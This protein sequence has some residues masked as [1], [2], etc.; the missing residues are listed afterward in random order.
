MVSVTVANRIRKKSSLLSRKGSILVSVRGKKRR[1]RGRK[2][3]EEGAF[4]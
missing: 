4:W 3:G 1:G 2:E